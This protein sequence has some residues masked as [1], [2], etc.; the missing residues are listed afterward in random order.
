[1]SKQPQI[2]CTDCNRNYTLDEASK[3]IKYYGTP[4]V[5]LCDCK[6]PIEY[7]IELS[8]SEIKLVAGSVKMAHHINV[9]D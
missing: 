7:D 4:I 6:T 5:M 8:E 9:T 1:M 3:R 2:T